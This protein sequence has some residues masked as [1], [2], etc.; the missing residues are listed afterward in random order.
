MPGGAGGFK[1]NNF[2]LSK[3]FSQK[4]NHEFPLRTEKVFGLT[5]QQALKFAKIAYNSNP[6]A[7]AKDA[8]FLSDLKFDLIS[9]SQSVLAENEDNGY[10]GHIFSSPT[11]VVVATRGT[12]GGNIASV[13][14]LIQ[15]LVKKDTDVN[16]KSIMSNM[17]L[18][19]DLR[20]DLVSDLQLS[21][22]KI[23][24]QVISAVKFL[25][26]NNHVFIQA[27]AENKDVIF[28][29]H[30]LGA[31]MSQVLQAKSINVLLNS[32]VEGSREW[33]KSKIHSITFDNPG[34]AESLGNYFDARIV[35]YVAAQSV[36]I[37]ESPNM[38]NTAN[39]QVGKVYEV[40]NE[41]V[42]FTE[43]MNPTKWVACANNVLDDFGVKERL[44]FGVA[45][46]MLETFESQI[47]KTSGM[48]VHLDY[49]PDWN[50]EV[51]GLSVNTDEMALALA[52][53]LSKIGNAYSGYYAS[54]LDG[55]EKATE[56]LEGACDM[57][58]KI[59]GLNDHPDL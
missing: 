11:S 19:N 42:S 50:S 25:K 37:Q 39:K 21:A 51:S 41:G 16:L 3:L 4:N 43:C 49:R 55:V 56:L 24:D 6:L 5:D 35:A 15:A 9:S 52:N 45:T 13:M 58:S 32:S 17:N 1:L 34:S 2:D 46:H 7:K 29:G 10:Q 14:K 22:G 33:A 47:N 23:P 12:D 44:G 54:A 57:A 59:L 26:A 30:S 40:I 18:L 28:I 36:V 38:I 20:G 53:K 8:K 48:F 27:I 31:F